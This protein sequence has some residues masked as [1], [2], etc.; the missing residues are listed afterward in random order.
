MAPKK[1]QQIASP[2]TVA[3]GLS[4]AD[5]IQR[6]AALVQLAAAGFNTP[7]AVSE[8]LELNIPSKL[9]E[10][11]QQPDKHLKLLACRQ[12]AVFAAYGPESPLQ[13]ALSSTQTV[14]VY[15]LRKTPLHEMLAAIASLE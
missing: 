14:Q 1:E 6:Q 12:L 9:V 8:I 15:T 5:S 2:A 13:Q 10:C 7:Q 3:N 11:L 4:S